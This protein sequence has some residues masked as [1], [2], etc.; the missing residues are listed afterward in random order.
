[1]RTGSETADTL[2]STRNSSKSEVKLSDFCFERELG[3]GGFGQ[4]WS[5]RSRRHTNNKRFA[6]KQIYKVLHI[7]ETAVRN[8]INE[9][10][11]MK[12]IKSDFVVK[13]HYALQEERHLYL[14]MDLMSGGDLWQ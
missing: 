12:Q 1:M 5:A 2:I 10:N 8:L 9:L 3:R 7:R 13:L 11:F 14:V 6:I 4:V